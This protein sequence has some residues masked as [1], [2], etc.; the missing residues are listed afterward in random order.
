VARCYGHR[1]G[2]LQGVPNLVQR[3]QQVLQVSPE[4]A[5]VLVGLGDGELAG[6]HAARDIVVVICTYTVRHLHR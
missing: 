4:L 2:L 1:L 5:H 3:S 6:T